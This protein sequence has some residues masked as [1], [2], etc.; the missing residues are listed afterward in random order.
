M[1]WAL[2]VMHHDF[3]FPAVK[4]FVANAALRIMGYLVQS[5]YKDFLQG[6]KAIL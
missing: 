4:K 2:N 5:I 6:I 3:E 1:Q